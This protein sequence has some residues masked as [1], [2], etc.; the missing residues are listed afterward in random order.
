VGLFAD[1]LHRKAALDALTAENESLKAEI[2]SLN[3]QLGKM[4]LKLQLAE[5]MAQ[6]ALKVNQVLLRTHKKQ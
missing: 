3:K 5:E 1:I 2:A 6:D 4:A